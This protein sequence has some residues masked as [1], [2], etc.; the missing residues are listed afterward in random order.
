[1]QGNWTVCVP[2]K[3]LIFLPDIQEANCFGANLAPPL[4]F[5]FCIRP[6][7]QFE[8]ICIDKYEN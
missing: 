5:Y 4:D 7:E 8:R 3:Y 2:L 6:W 1:M